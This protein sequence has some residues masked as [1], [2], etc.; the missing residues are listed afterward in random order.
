MAVEQP[1]VSADH[2]V[3]TSSCDMCNRLHDVQ[4][5]VKHLTEITLHAGGM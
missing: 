5:D 3:L 4:H 2:A 1:R